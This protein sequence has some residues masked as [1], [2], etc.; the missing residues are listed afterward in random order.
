MDRSLFLV[1][2]DGFLGE[3]E[4]GKV[5]LGTSELLEDRWVSPKEA[6]GPAGNV[7]LAAALRDCGDGKALIALFDD[8]VLERDKGSEISG[9][10]EDVDGVEEGILLPFHSHVHIACFLDVPKA[11]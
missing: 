4:P 7:E 5:V 6:R 3:P 8:D 2:V 9:L 1:D 10:G 11:G